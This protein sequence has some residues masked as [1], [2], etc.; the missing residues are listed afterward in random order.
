M[1][2]SR[3]LLRLGTIA[4]CALLAQCAHTSN[5]PTQ[6]AQPQAPRAT[7][8]TAEDSRKDL[9]TL[10]ELVQ[11]EADPRDVRITT[12]GTT[13]TLA[14]LSYGVNAFGGIVPDDNIL[15]SI[16]FSNGTNNPPYIHIQTPAQSSVGY[17]CD[18]NTLDH[19]LDGI[20]PSQKDFFFMN[21]NGVQ[22]VC[23]GNKNEGV[24]V[25]DGREECKDKVAIDQAYTAHIR[26][27]L[28]T[29][30]HSKRW[31]ELRHREQMRRGI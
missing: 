11:R 31:N 10:A 21:C 26:R 16:R 14:F 6:Q 30:G 3:N 9:K 4:L 5:E 20:R 17:V 8:A 24:V 15:Y 2:L 12:E 7:H 29:Y 22:Y 18:I 23:G 13:Y 25:R 28:D 19:H 27:I 1:Y